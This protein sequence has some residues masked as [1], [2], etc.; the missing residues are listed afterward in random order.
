MKLT[1]CRALVVSALA[2]PIGSYAQTSDTCQAVSIGCPV[3]GGCVVTD[4]FRRNRKNPVDGVVRHH[5]GVDYRAARGTPV[6]AAAN[7]RVEK[8]YTSKT[9]GEV[10]VIR[11]DDGS[12]TLYAHLEKRL[13]EE[14]D[15]EVKKGRKRPAEAV[16]T[17]TRRRRF[18]RRVLR[19][20][21]T[22][23]AR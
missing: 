23:E 17:I 5:N 8:S 18:D 11:H 2:I 19:R 3:Q 15:G 4:P 21:S 1:L 22:A 6:L 12:A 9:Y 14:G 20:Y 10:I 16:L 13:V 7:G